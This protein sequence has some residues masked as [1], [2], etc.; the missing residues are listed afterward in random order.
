MLAANLLANS[1]FGLNQTDLGENNWDIF[2]YGA[3]DTVPA[4]QTREDKFKGWEISDAVELWSTG[5]GGW[6]E[7]DSDTNGP[8]HHWKTDPGDT[9][10]HPDRKKLTGGEHG[11]TSIWQTVDVEAG[12]VY[13]LSFEFGGRNGYGADDNK[14]KV[15]VGGA[16]TAVENTYTLTGEKTIYFTATG[17]QVTVKFADAGEDNTFGTLI[18]EIS[19]EETPWALDLDID[20]DNVGGIEESDWEDELENNPYGLGKLLETSS[21]V[22][23]AGAA[24]P[25]GTYTP[26]LLA[27]PAGLDPSDPSVKIRFDFDPTGQAGSYRIW[28]ARSTNPNRVNADALD[29]GHRI[30][31]GTEYPL[32]KLRYDSDGY[33]DIFIDGFSET[34][35]KTLK[36]VET[37]GKPEETIKATIVLNG[38]DLISDEVKYI[39][40]NRP[41]F[42]WEL[43]ER[44]EVRDELASRGV[45]GEEG[46]AKDM[47][48]F[49]LERLDSK[50]L[51]DLGVPLEIASLLS[52]TN[53]VP[54]FTAA[55]YRDY[56]GG[57]T[58]YALAFAGTNDVHDLI[59]DIWQGVGWQSAQYPAAM[60]IA[61]RLI[62]TPGIL[63]NLRTTGHSLGGGLASAASVV[64]AIP[65]NTFNAAGLNVKSLMERDAAGNL[66]EDENG[67][68]IAIYPNSLTNYGN[69][70]GLINAYFVDWDLLSFV[71]DHS[72]LVNALG[73]RI[74]MDGPFDQT[75]LIDGA[76]VAGAYA[77]G[78][79][80]ATPFISALTLYTMTEAHFN[81]T[82]LYGLLVDEGADTDLL[83]YDL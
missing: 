11:S 49:S 23:T 56:I 16:T 69:A 68:N 39:I 38:N 78:Q 35:R 20:S 60:K 12:K 8:R 65:A 45:Y 74:E 71:Q 58:D 75:L 30:Q 3:S 53:D 27:I 5:W 13:A 7:L 25:Y 51:L 37:L 6:V 34:N 28:T 14:L 59:E 29:G 19:L 79:V 72:P 40:T 48:D 54:G 21:N 15:T 9:T 64:A 67:N 46:V 2:H 44:R 57:P 81:T 24:D 83:G 1:D 80:W 32:S 73:T 36:D 62:R 55:L 10:V 61:D 26:V 76:L 42:F 66:L 52:A 22:G 33:I 77:S 63:G 47:P 70:N 43:Q 4:E 82:V 41:S 31:S 18:R 17:T 50:D